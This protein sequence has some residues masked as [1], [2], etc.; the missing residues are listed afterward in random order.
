LKDENVEKCPSTA[1][2]AQEAKQALEEATKDIQTQLNQDPSAPQDE[3]VQTD[4][5]VSENPALPASQSSSQALETAIEDLKKQL[6]EAKALADLRAKEARAADEKSKKLAVKANQVDKLRN[7]ADDLRTKL[8][9]LQN[10][11]VTPPIS[12][13][14]TPMLSVKGGGTAYAASQSGSAGNAIDIAGTASGS[15]LSGSTN[16]AAMTTGNDLPSS[17]IGGVSVRGR[18]SARGTAMRARVRGGGG[19]RPPTRGIN[20]QAILSREY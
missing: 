7:T 5:I 13:L 15:S 8:H 2:L 17:A 1:Q 19:A 16:T 20:P 11:K 14:T 18:G 12:G 4:P 3:G 10:A 6:E 9:E